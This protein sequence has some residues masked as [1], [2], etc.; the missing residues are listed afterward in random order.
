MLSTLY[1]IARPSVCLS[2]RRVDHRT[3]SQAV[4][5]IAYRTASWHLWVTWRHRSRDHLIANVPFPI[6]GVL[7]LEIWRPYVALTRPW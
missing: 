6:G 7:A 5:R 1:A 4:A 2:V 3:R